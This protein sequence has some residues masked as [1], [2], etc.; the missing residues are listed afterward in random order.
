M[1]IYS[2]VIFLFIF[3]IIQSIGT[4]FQIKLYK[5]TVKR[6][7]EKANIGIGSKKNIFSRNIVII[8]CDNSCKITGAQIFDGITMF[9]RFKDIP[10]IIGKD[11]Y[12]LKDTYNLLSDKEKKKL[13]G[14]IQALNSLCE[15]M[16]RKIDI[17]D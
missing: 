1:E 12:E 16:Q 10:N 8:A 11:I 2:I 15:Y 5:N 9:S 17:I 4:I 14:H 7:N 6:L 3:M 13:A